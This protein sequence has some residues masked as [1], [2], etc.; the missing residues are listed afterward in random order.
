MTHREVEEGV[1]L[2]HVSE[3]IGDYNGGFMV[4]LWC[5]SLFLLAACVHDYSYAARSTCSERNIMVGSSADYRRLSE[6]HEH[7]TS[8]LV[9]PCE[10]F[11]IF[12]CFNWVQNES[13]SMF[14]YSEHSLNVFNEAIKDLPLKILRRCCFSAADTKINQDDF[15][16]SFFASLAQMGQMAR[17]PSSM[18]G[19]VSDGIADLSIRDEAENFKKCVGDYLPVMQKL[20]AE[21]VPIYGA[22]PYNN[23]F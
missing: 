18:V 2:S 4:E 11:F 1:A 16:M 21:N 15:M 20:I 6:L 13:F 8:L 7:A 14:S 3:H 17:L 22:F 10:D 12:A 5:C 19:N 23:L 9:D